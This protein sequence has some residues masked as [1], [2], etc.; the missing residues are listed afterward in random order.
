MLDLLALSPD[1]SLFTVYGYNTLLY[2]R[3]YDSSSYINIVFKCYVYLY[4]KELYIRKSRQNYTEKWA[5]EKWSAESG[6][7]DSPSSCCSVSADRTASVKTVRTA[8]IVKTLMSGF[9]FTGPA[10]SFKIK[11]P[12]SQATRSRQFGRK[13]SNTSA[14]PSQEWTEMKNKMFPL[15][16]PGRR[17]SASQHSTG[18]T[19]GTEVDTGAFKIKAWGLEHKII[20]LKYNRNN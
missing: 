4:L 17:K 12:T 1:P 15:R 10:A 13:C 20:H 2:V 8:R 7:S 19:C 3:L 6:S 14:D 16:T 18:R 11:A 5:G 9:M